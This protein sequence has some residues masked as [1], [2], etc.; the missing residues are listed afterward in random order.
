MSTPA[1]LVGRHGYIN[2]THPIGINPSNPISFFFED[3]GATGLRRSLQSCG[4]FLTH[5]VGKCLCVCVCKIY[6]ILCNICKYVYI[7]VY[8]ILHILKEYIYCGCIVVY[9]LLCIDKY[10][11]YIVPKQSVRK[12]HSNRLGKSHHLPCFFSLLFGVIG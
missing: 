11:A 6:I 8:V 9:K 1:T 2:P 12:H 4:K 5:N 7:Y 10:T 3:L